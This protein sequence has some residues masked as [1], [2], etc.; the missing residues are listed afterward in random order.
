MGVIMS[1]EAGIRIMATKLSMISFFEPIKKVVP[2]TV[3]GFKEVN[4]VTQ[5]KTQATD[6]CDASIYIVGLCETAELYLSLLVFLLEGQCHCKISLVL[7]C[8]QA[9]PVPKR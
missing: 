4:I 2:I 1:M 5:V 6:S 8:F 7:D 3:V 9:I